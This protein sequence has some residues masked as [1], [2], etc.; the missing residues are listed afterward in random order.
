MCM[1][2]VLV[3]EGLMFDIAEVVWQAYVYILFKANH[4]TMPQEKSTQH[5][6]V[7]RMST[8]WVELVFRIHH[9]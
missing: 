1:G 7:S 6:T 4:M 8:K 2:K 9:E 5:R 3:V